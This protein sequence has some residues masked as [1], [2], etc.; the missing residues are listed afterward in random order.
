[1]VD[2]NPARGM[3]RALERYWLRGKGA[4][5]IRWG[6]PH[7]FNRCVRN[8]RKYFPK[9]P[10]GLCNILHRKALGAPPGKGHGDAHAL[11]AA[12]PV[13]GTHLWAGPLAPVGRPTGEPRR[14]RIFEPG[15]LQHRELPLPLDW[16][17]RTGQGHEG[18]M[19]VGRILGIAYG[20]NEG[21]LEHAYGWGD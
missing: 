3:P 21:G 8:L 5:K 2:P 13:L 12:M 10:E 17:P 14:Q 11:L 7:D 6:M 9:E 15:A 1:M 18:A 16:R 20:P 19:T 4:A